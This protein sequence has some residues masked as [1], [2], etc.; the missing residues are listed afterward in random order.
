MTDIGRS[1]DSS[2]LLHGLEIWTQA[3]IHAKY[4]LVNDG[5]HRHAAEGICEVFPQLDIVPAF[6]FIIKAVY[7]VN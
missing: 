1:H 4:L 7:S 6:N 2:Y 5:C 3:T